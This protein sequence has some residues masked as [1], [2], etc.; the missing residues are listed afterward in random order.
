MRKILD[1][2]LK[3]LKNASDNDFGN[4]ID[5]NELMTLIKYEIKIYAKKR[6]INRYITP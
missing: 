5:W 1:N 2:S 6:G 3:F 4:V